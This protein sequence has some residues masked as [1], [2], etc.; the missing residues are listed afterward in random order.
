MRSRDWRLTLFLLWLAGACLRL[1]VLAVPPLVPRIHEQ[2]RLDETAIGFLTGMPVLLVALVAVPGSLLIARIGARR[3]LI[4]SLLLIAAAGAARGLFDTPFQLFAMTFLMGCG[5]SAAQPAMPALV[6]SWLPNR[7]GVGTASFS[8]GILIGEI[9]AVATTLPVIMLLVHQSWQLALAVWSVPVAATAGLV[10]LV[11]THDPPTPGSV[12]LMWW[13]DWRD[14]TIWKLGLIL[15][16][17]SSAYWTA[18]AFIP[19]YLRASH[20]SALITAALASLNIV[21]LPS[22]ILVALLPSRLI[23]RRWPL[24]IAGGLTIISAG[25]IV[26]LPASWIVVPAGLLGFSTALVFVLTLAL[27]PLLAKPSDTHRLSAG[28]FT[29]SYVCPFL[30]SLLSGAMWD[31]TG[32]DWTAFMTVVAGGL[33]MLLL[34]RR[35]ALLASMKSAGGEVNVPLSMTP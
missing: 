5:I 27:P 32:H 33:L 1:T 8:N 24:A 11:T 6:K 30:G 35:L 28:I 7:V 2:L 17:A 22:S 25:A 4:C 26:M 16:G 29:V 15:G 10:G 21:Q 20:H 34:P 18:N 19:D 3:A 9:L 13:P 23:A 31:L 14:S 12:P